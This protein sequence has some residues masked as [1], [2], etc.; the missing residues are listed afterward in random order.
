[1]MNHFEPIGSHQQVLWGTSQNLKNRYWQITQ[2][3]YRAWVGVLQLHLQAWAT[4]E[5]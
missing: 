5:T 4:R 2:S 3:L 1:M